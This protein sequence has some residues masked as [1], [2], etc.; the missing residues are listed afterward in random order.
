[1]IVASHSNIRMKTGPKHIHT[2]FLPGARS[3]DHELPLA[4]KRKS[5]NLKSSKLFSCSE[6]SKFP[7]LVLNYWVSTEYNLLWPFRAITSEQVATG[8]FPD[9][10]VSFPGK[11]STTWYNDLSSSVAALA[12]ERR[13]RNGIEDLEAS[14]M[15]MLSLSSQQV[16]PEFIPW[17]PLLPV[18]YKYCRPVFALR[19]S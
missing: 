8:S 11:S 3:E 10:S 17:S 9:P 12:V 13:T 1:M 5:S 15:F 16:G 14:I 2:W 6:K 4:R 7:L 18:K 19:V